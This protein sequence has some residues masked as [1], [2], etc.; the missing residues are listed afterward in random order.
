MLT[1]L[2]TAKK[3]LRK[4]VVS[5]PTD[6]VT[7]ILEPTG[8]KIQR[9]RNWFY[10]E[11]HRGPTLM[12]TLSCEDSRSGS[13]YKTGVRIQVFQRVK[14]G[15]GKSAEQF[16]RDFAAAKATQARVIESFPQLEQ[17]LFRR[18]GMLTEEGPDRI[19][20]SLFWG[21]N[22]IDI[23]VVSIAGTSK[24]LWNVYAATFQKMSEFEII[25]MTRFS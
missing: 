3:W 20:Y 12:W 7:Q 1:W 17:G 16:I 4:T 5:E 13:P 10:S 11:G 18:I 14:T 21:K 2:S 19:L 23:A 24:D 9:P 25:D 22:D 15:T 6:F 8:G